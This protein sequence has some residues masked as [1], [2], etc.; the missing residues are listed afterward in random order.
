MKELIKS[1]EELYEELGE[2]NG[3]KLANNLMLE[4]KQEH[5]FKEFVDKC[6]IEEDIDTFMEKLKTEKWS[7][8]K[9]GERVTNNADLTIAKVARELA[10]LRNVML[11]KKIQKE[12]DFKAV[13]NKLREI[14][15]EIDTLSETTKHRKDEEDIFE[16]IKKVIANILD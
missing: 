13:A 7:V 15:D 3:E 9:N 8:T 6:Y 4:L 10:I 12:N 1:L 16:E 5:S 2:T 11:T 14:A